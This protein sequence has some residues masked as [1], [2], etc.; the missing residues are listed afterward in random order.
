[1]MD[2]GRVCLKIAGRDA[3]KTCVIVEKINDTYV[4]I[5]GQTR[6]RKC[7]VKHLEPMN[8]LIDIKEKASHDNVVEAF[9]KLNLE[10]KETK[11]KN[12]SQKPTKSRKSA[13]KQKSVDNKEGKN[14]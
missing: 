11:P 9:K 8:Q 3:H 1:M 12:A 6:R 14:Y 13:N 2:I 7:N 10:I 5:D 4:I